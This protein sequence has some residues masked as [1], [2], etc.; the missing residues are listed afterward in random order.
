MKRG[1]WPGLGLARGIRLPADRRATY[2]MPGLASLSRVT[3]YNSA[4]ATRPSL[5][6]LYPGSRLS[7]NWL[8]LERQAA[9]L[10]VARDSLRLLLIGLG[11]VSK[12]LLDKQSDL[13]QLAWDSP[14]A[15]PMCGTF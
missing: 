7:V 10:R 14:T 15:N 12:W 13:T 2:P 4:Q 11:S 1:P 5:Y 3:E 6:G 9:N 8:E